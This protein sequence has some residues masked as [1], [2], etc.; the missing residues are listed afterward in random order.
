[1]SMLETYKN[2]KQIQERNTD[3]SITKYIFR[4]GPQELENLPKPIL[5]MYEN[6]LSENDG[7]RFFYF[8]NTDCVSFIEDIYGKEYLVYY[9]TLKPTA[10]KADFWRYLVLYE[11]GGCYGD[12]TQKM[13]ITYDELC[14]GFEQVFCR[15]T[16]SSKHGLYNALMCSY[17]KNPIIYRAIE[18]CID[19]I[20]NK[21]YQGSSLDITGPYVLG[22]AY[23]EAGI[24]GRYIGEPIKLGII[25]KTKILTNPG[26]ENYI[27]DADSNIVCKKKMDIHVETIYNKDNVYYNDL[28][29][30]R[31]IYN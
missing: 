2:L 12:F 23:Q 31:D 3:K 19:N 28:W 18:I 9:N 11:Y 7:Y 17:P 1:M 6:M 21:R 5:E 24:D 29:V 15:D 27:K 22:R 13:Y 14:N 8:S 4:T 16:H 26:Y 30:K 20:S 10:F 25:D